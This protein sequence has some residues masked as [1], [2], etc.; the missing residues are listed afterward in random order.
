MRFFP[1]GRAVGGETE[2]W[3]GSD[4]EPGENSRKIYK[5]FILPSRFRVAIGAGISYNDMMKNFTA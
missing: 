5:I 2:E 4:K 3:A 1:K